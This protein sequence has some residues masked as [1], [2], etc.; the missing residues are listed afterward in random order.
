MSNQEPQ[1]P[2]ENRQERWAQEGER[3]GKSASA[4]IPPVPNFVMSQPAGGTPPPDAPA[5]AAQ[6]QSQ[7]GGDGA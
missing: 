2:P 4:D 1:Q 5:Q 6:P 3:A 7:P